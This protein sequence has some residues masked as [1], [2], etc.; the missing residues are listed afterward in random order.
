MKQTA[1]ASFLLAL[2]VGTLADNLWQPNRELVYKYE[3]QLEAG[4]FYPA[5]RVSQW[6]MTGTLVVHGAENQAT[7]QFRNLTVSTYNGP[8][9][10][11]NPSLY[12]PVPD[13]ASQLLQPF[14]IQYNAG[15]VEDLS[16]KAGEEE[17]AINM[18]RGLAS[19]LQLDL[20]QLQS[21]AAVS[22]ESGLHGRCKV[23][24]S[25]YNHSSGRIQT[26]KY[27]DLSACAGYP[28]HTSSN[29][30]R[31]PCPTN[32]QQSPVSSDSVRF[33]TL[34]PSGPDKQ[35]VVHH[36]LADGGIYLHPFKGQ[37]DSHFLISRV[38]LTLQEQGD[39]KAQIAVKGGGVRAGLLYRLPDEDVTQGRSPPSQ[40]DLLDAVNEILGELGD[41]L[42][43]HDLETNLD[44]LHEERVAHVLF[45][46]SL[47][48][49]TSLRQLYSDLAVG[50]SYR[51]ETLRNLFLEILPLVGSH[52]SKLL[53]RDLVMGGALKNDTA[54][55][56]LSA[57]PFTV[58]HP[59]EQLLS[60]LEVLLTLPEDSDVYQTAVL[61]FATLV[62]KVCS[63]HCA[64]ETQDKY[65]GK[66]LDLFADSEDYGHQMLY[67]EA[68]SNFDLDRVVQYLE[69]IIR[70]E[71]SKYSHHLRFLAVWATMNHARLQPDQMYRLYMPILVNR[72]EELEMR[73]A[74][75]TMLVVSQPTLTRFYNIMYVMAN[76]PDPHLQHFWYTTLQSLANTKYPCYE[77]MGEVAKMVVRHYPEPQVRHWATGNYI[78]D[79]T[80][81][82]HAFGSLAHLFMVANPRTG[83]P[84]VF[85]LDVGSHAMDSSYNQD[86]VYVKLVGLGDVVKQQL[87]RTNPTSL[88]VS[89]LLDLLKQLQ[90]PS[91][92]VEPLHVELIVK[93]QNKVVMVHHANQSSF[94]D[95][96]QAVNNAHLIAINGVHL[97]AQRVLVPVLLEE[98]R[99]TDLGTAAL[100]RVSNAW[101]HSARANYTSTRRTSSQLE[102]RFS[103]SMQTALTQYNPVLNMWHGIQRSFNLQGN[104]PFNLEFAFDPKQKNIKFTFQL[105][106]GEET[107]LVAHVRTTVFVRGIA[108]STKLASHCPTCQSYV[109][110][111][112]NG[113][114]SLRQ[115]LVQ[116]ELSGMKLELALLDCEYSYDKD[117]F[118][119]LLEHVSAHQNYHVFPAS[120]PLLTAVHLLD[121][122]LLVPPSGSCG[123]LAKMVPSGT[124]PTQVELTLEM[125]KSN[126]SS[127]SLEPLPAGE[128]SLHV[129]VVRTPKS[130][131]APDWDLSVN[132]KHTQAL[133]SHRVTAQL[134]IRDG[135]KVCV[136]VRAEFPEPSVA[137]PSLSELQ[138]HSATGD[139]TV[140]WGT[141]TEGTQCPQESSLHVTVDG[142]VTATQQALAKEGQA[143]PYGSCKT[144]LKDEKQW[145]THYT[146][147]TRACYETVRELATLRHYNVSITSNN[148]PKWT[149][150]LLDLIPSRALSSLSDNIT[151]TLEVPQ[152]SKPELTVNGRKT[153]LGAAAGRKMKPW[154]LNTQFP[155]LLQFAT[156]MG[157]VGTCVLTSSTV[158]TLDGAN[159]T[160]NIPTCYTLA[161]TDCSSYPHFALFVKK[162]EGTTSPLAIKLYLQDK[163]VEVLPIVDHVII[164]VNDQVIASP[165]EG[166]QSPPGYADYEFKVWQRTDGLIRVHLGPLHVWLEYYGHFATV[167]VLGLYRGELCGLCGDHNGNASD[168]QAQVFSLPCTSN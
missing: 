28:V 87:M 71:D 107:G 77:H 8:K 151:L 93:E 42:E 76:D 13:H 2:V 101:L 7:L 98:L 117:E 72:S 70:G 163:H 53:V 49:R 155:P 3:A 158:W 160:A 88:T 104:F 27:L 126:S 63:S 54:D 166:Y 116:L 67:L 18:K 75:L 48:N 165:Q 97:N 168:D 46:L 122:L 134:N 32:S 125:Q 128:Y 108:A 137:V 102:L 78:L 133:S 115:N 111:K 100:L 6:S 164:S 112:K 55:Q 51:H 109:V 79:Y 5:P 120:S 68:L 147:L 90:L 30:Q 43:R 83:L 23:E 16:V 52:D 154:L 12:T 95:F 118:E 159:L 80:D 91:K 20:S 57:F 127:S 113:H 150:S 15:H 21:K 114:N 129:E 14:I 66:Y 130:S 135:K 47:L 156:H 84:A 64:P 65:V 56:L 103:A 19:L 62:H 157:A 25:T 89:Q 144:D 146:P 148:L 145:G 86:S 167:T 17:W 138:P 41:N 96:L 38:Q 132:Y 99:T 153:A 85:Y 44:K 11:Y 1:R 141:S 4:T 36:I 82:D 59:S 73:V 81:V 74:A 143:W 9:M 123:L 37:L 152:S 124:L 40:G 110:V 22:H 61:S 131:S 106:P 162:V 140:Q 161:L 45:F 29:T 10:H 92:T 121:Y 39:I 50:T 35:L 60:D 58:H 119:A 69:P 26:R 24:Y 34:E 33:Y 136:D 149:D 142:E 139:L 94:N 105:T 31:V